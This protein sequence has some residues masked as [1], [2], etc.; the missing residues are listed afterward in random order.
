MTE[1][2]IE[3]EKQQSINQSINP[4][5]YKN[6][7]KCNSCCCCCLSE[8]ASVAIEYESNADLVRNRD[9]HS[10]TKSSRSNELDDD[11]E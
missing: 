4:R 7:W 2:K 3:K 6:K 11:E 10:T 5:A 8:N 9:R 1:K